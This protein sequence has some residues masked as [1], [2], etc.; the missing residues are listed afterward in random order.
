MTI[1]ALLH[2]ERLKSLLKIYQVKRLALFG[3][4]AN[5]IAGKRSDVDFLVEFKTGADL[6]DQV[7]L[8][9]DLEAL[10]K[11]RVDVVTPN[12]LSKYFRDKVLKEAVY[13]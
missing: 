7:G 2:S 11:K 4:Y 12:S 3:S 8:K 5:G 6:L 9:Q 10:L 13:L 1:R